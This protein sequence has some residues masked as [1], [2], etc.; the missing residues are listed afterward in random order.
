MY[1]DFIFPAVLSASHRAAWQLEDVMPA[2]A[3][4][5]FSRPLLPETLARAHDVAGLG[6]AERLTLNHIRGHEYL[7]IF[8]LVEEFIVPF[9][10]DHV[11]DSLDGDDQRIRALLQ[12]ASEEAKH[13]HP[14]KRFH[15]AFVAGFGMSCEVIGPPEAIAAEVLRHHSLSV[16]LVILQIEWMTQR[17][18]L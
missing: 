14:F 11:R 12:F 5:D 4:L 17:H 9:V 7:S 10:L 3:Q 18:Y 8:G 2:G 13:I 1:H 6:E 16:A 15:G